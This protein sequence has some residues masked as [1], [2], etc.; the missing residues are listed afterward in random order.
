MNFS[1]PN[2]GGSD[3]ALALEADVGEHVAPEPADAVIAT[4]GLTRSFKGG[5]D[6]VR[7]IDLRV[8]A[9]EVFGFLGPNGA[10]KTTTVRM[11]CTLLPPTAG[12]ATVAGLDV[13]RDAADVRR[14]IGVALQEIGLDPAQSGRELLELQCGL[15]GITGKRARERTQELLEL[16]GLTD[17]AERRTKTYSGGMKRRLDL[18]SALV[19]KPDVL[20]LDE[21]TTGLD[22]AS[23]RTI[24]DEVRRINAGGATVFLT[25]QYL[26]E[27]DQLCHRVAIIDGGEIVAEGTPEQLKAELGHDV[28]SIALNGADQAD[29]E[30][31]L[32]GLPGLERVVTEQRALAL[33]V[34][35]GAGSIVEIVRRLER[36]EIQVGA[37]S[38][39]R[40]TLDDV[41]LKATGRRLEG[42][43]AETDEATEVA[44]R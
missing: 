41:F 40:P 13:V 17:A 19:H 33:Y 30:A 10:G 8:G 3:M 18:A 32:A 25:T 26:E 22:P 12:G 9:G 2:N 29:T 5:I 36:A 14:R 16:V 4:H 6:A 43:A 24:W 31:A 1:E 35:D 37:I 27:A 44:E 28:V 7:G 34:E 15:Y 23:R 11:L 42:A 39:A 38:V 21:P 20:F